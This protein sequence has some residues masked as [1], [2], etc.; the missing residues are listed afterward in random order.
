MKRVG[1]CICHPPEALAQYKVLHAA[2][3]P[4]VLATIKRP[5]I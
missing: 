5:N 1:T 2:V 4:E 3:W